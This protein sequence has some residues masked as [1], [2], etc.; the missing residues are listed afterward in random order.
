MP[1]E[2]S[3]VA[4]ASVALADEARATSLVRAWRRAARRPPALG[5]AAVVLFYVFLAIAAPWIAPDDP[6]R[7]DWSAIRKGPSAAHLFGTDDLG[8]DVLSRVIY[9]T[10]ISMQAGVFSILLAMAIG[11]PAGLVAGFYRGVFDQLI[12]RL[13]DAWLS[14]PFLILAIGLVT[15]LGPSLINATVAI[16]VGATP[17]YI[18]LT[19]GLVLS[20]REEDFGDGAPHPAQHQQRA[21]RA[22]HRVCSRRH[23]RRGDPLL[24][25]AGRAAPAAELGHHVEHRPAV[26][27]NRA[28]DG[29]VAG[30]GHLLPRSLLQPGGRRPA[31]LAGSEGLLSAAPSAAEHLDERGAAGLG[32]AHLLRE[33][34]ARA[35]DALAASDAD[36]ETEAVHREHG[37]LLGGRVRVGSRQGHQ[38]IGMVAVHVGDDLLGGVGEG[39]RRRRRVTWTG[40][41]VHRRESAHE[42]D[43]R[44]LETP[45]AEVLEVDP[46]GSPWLPDEVPLARGGAL[47]LGQPPGAAHQRHPASRE[48]IVGPAGLS[49]EQARPRI[50]FEVLGVH[51][52]AA[53]EEQRRAAMVRRIG[54]D[55]AEGMARL[56]ARERGQRTR[57]REMDEGPRPLRVARLGRGR[58]RVGLWPGSRV[59][60]HVRSSMVTAASGRRRA[61]STT[62]MRSGASRFRTVSSWRGYARPSTPARVIT[63]SETTRSQWYSLVSASRRL[64]TCTVSPTAVR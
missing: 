48:R 52:H 11:V 41:P 58:Q 59:T 56:P 12:M 61:S 6:L 45:E 31:R 29:V 25:G 64:A 21:A 9:G 36:A 22:G 19:R 54:H 16:G 8:R 26:P 39:I 35:V 23:H 43:V 63:C 15:I 40:D 1:P 47:R 46:V 57:A 28:V 13:T 2:G 27:G 4:T 50:A 30:A 53:D 33:R 37:R 10:R 51:G 3:A 7:T 44:H 24:P 55:R 17:T 14:F 42:V 60:A 20:T 62:T 18:R 5:G 32:R 49:H 38:R 34:D